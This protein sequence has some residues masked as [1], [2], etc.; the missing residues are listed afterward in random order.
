MRR[1]ST[2]GIMKVQFLLGE[3]AANPGL[4]VEI[5][6]EEEY[7]DWQ[8]RERSLQPCASSPSVKVPPGS[9]SGRWRSQD[10]TPQLMQRPVSAHGR[11]LRNFSSSS[12]YF[13]SGLQ[14]AVG[15]AVGSSWGVP[16]V[17]AQDERYQKA[18]RLREEVQQSKEEKIMSRIQQR[19][20]AA[21]Y[22]M[23]QEQLMVQQK[24]W[25][26]SIAAVARLR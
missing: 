2:D 18:L 5:N 7:D 15:S 6:E 20:L 10:S 25:L 8:H 14:S 12:D 9:G 24:A 16:Q 4:F 1:A 22:R 13:N 11:M 26:L 17:M 21:Q 23:E 3:S 19:E